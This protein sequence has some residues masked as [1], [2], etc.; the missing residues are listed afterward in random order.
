MIRKFTLVELLIVI[1]IIAILA[2]ML[3]PALRSALNKANKMSCGSN[4]KQIY[5]ALNQYAGDNDDYLPVSINYTS[6]GGSLGM[7]QRW[8]DYLLRY[9]TSSPPLFKQQLY[10]QYPV[11]RCPSKKNGSLE[12]NYAMNESLSRKKTIKI[13]RPRERFLVAEVLDNDGTAVNSQIIS[14][15]WT[16]GSRYIDFQCHSGPPNFLTAAGALV[17]QKKPWLDAQAAN[18]F[19]Y[20]HGE[21]YKGGSDGFAK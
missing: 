9:V 10:M 6:L 21:Y 3:L 18:Y 5:L 12:Q 19:S 7:Y 15:S 2:A 1:A 16:S 20:W 11:F 4:L 17:E 13:V 8:Q 14:L